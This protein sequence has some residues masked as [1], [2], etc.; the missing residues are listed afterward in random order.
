MTAGA[1]V[2]HCGSTQLLRAWFALSPSAILQL[3]SPS[4]GPAVAVPTLDRELLSRAQAGDS[5]AFEALIRPHLGSIRRLAF[6]FARGW[7]DADDLA[8][9]AL[10]K[11]F[12]AL[13]SFQE[14]SEF[15]TWLYSVTRNVCRDFYRGVPARERAQEELFDEEAPSSSETSAALSAEELLASK[16]EA[17]QL[18][19]VLKELA[20]EFRVPLVLF[21]VEGLA[22]EEIAKIEGVPIG[23]IR[24]R[25]ARAR[26]QLKRRIGALPRDTPPPPGTNLPLDPSNQGS[27]P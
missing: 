26:E 21:E 22:Y 11:A 27:L 10:L 9:E 16:G 25:L 12:R 6:A 4:N 3:A 20:P 14:R 19:T 15:G 5:S 24:S 8:Q 2:R 18:W 7:A 1:A 13:D 17:E 23:T